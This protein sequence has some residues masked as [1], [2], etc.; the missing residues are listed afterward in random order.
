MAHHI[1]P[2]SHSSSRRRSRR[3]R[4]LYSTS[5][6]RIRRHRNQVLSSWGVLLNVA[7]AQSREFESLCDKSA[8]EHTAGIAQQ[9]K[10]PVQETSPAILDFTPQNPPT[11]F[12]ALITGAL[13]C[14]AIPAV[15]DVP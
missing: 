1:Q 13:S 7:L 12:D 15:C 2:V 6:R 10:A 3:P 14:C 11:Q 4:Q 5:P 9:L 8:S